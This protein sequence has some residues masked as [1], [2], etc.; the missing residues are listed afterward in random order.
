MNQNEFWSDKSVKG[1][2]F[3]PIFRRI[4]DIH[5]GIWSILYY[6][7]WEHHW[8]FLLNCPR[9]KHEWTVVPTENPYCWVCQSYKQKNK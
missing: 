1:P 7:S 5:R 6:G 9:G 2:W 4:R 3:Q 8:K